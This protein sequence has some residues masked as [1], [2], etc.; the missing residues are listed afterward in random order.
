MRIP[1]SSAGRLPPPNV[2]FI[3]L[4]KSAVP[5][6]PGAPAGPVVAA[7]PNA[8][9]APPVSGPRTLVIIEVCNCAPPVSRSTGDSVVV[10]EDG[11]SWFAAESSALC[12]E[13][14]TNMSFSNL[15]ICL[16]SP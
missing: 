15:A 16:A 5:G 6:A 3:A 1:G 14:P 12:D 4:A 13:P 2:A 10:P 9:G 8:L 11:A 7:A